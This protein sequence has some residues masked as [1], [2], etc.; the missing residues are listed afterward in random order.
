MMG[1]GSKNKAFLCQCKILILLGFLFAFDS[2]ASELPYET[3][4]GRF[5]RDRLTPMEVIA[6][7]PLASQANQMPPESVATSLESQQNPHNNIVIRFTQQTLRLMPSSLQRP[8][9]M[10]GTTVTIDTIRVYG[11]RPDGSF[12]VLEETIRLLIKTP[13]MIRPVSLDAFV[14]RGEDV[15]LGFSTPEVHIATPMT[16]IILNG[17]LIKDFSIN[18]SRRLIDQTDAYALTVGSARGDYHYQVASEDRFVSTM[19]Y[20]NG[21]EILSSIYED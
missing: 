3:V 16:D 2:F 12:G 7:L 5:C 9:Y 8:G 14:F 17:K 6:A 1:M 10:S 15:F 18:L 11:D 4:R 19:I 13:S 20:E 21:E